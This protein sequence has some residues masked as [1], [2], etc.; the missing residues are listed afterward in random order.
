MGGREGP[1][2]HVADGKNSFKSDPPNAF[3]TVFSA[4][5]RPAGAVVVLNNPRLA[6]NNLKYDA[7][8]MKGTAPATGIE[9]TLFIDSGG[10]PCDPQFDRGAGLSLLG[11]A[12]L[13]RAL[14]EWSRQERARDDAE[15]FNPDQGRSALAGSQPTFRPLQ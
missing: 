4:G 1:G 2:A 9:S 14:I 5:S 12:S 7:R 13:R 11:A 8:I 3:L 6:G 15:P 10:A